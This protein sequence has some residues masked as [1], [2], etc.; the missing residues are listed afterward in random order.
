GGLFASRYVIF[1]LPAL[2]FLY[3]LGMITVVLVV[4][5]WL[6]G[7]TG[8]Q[9]LLPAFILLAVLEVTAR[10]YGLYKGLGKDLA[11]FHARNS[12]VLHDTPACSRDIPYAPPDFEK[13]NDECREIPPDPVS[14]SIPAKTE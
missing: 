10:P 5:K 7:K 6:E 1:A 9:L 8:K 14:I 13:A 3:V 12:F 11:R 4:S 2:T